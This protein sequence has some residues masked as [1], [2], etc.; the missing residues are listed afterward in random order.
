MTKLF[1]ALFKA[2]PIPDSA[3]TLV[4]CFP[5]ANRH[6]DMRTAANRLIE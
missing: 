1:V 5:L 6:I 2:P 3:C 4:V